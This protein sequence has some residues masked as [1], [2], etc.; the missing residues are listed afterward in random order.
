MDAIILAGG[1]SAEDP[2]AA[3]AKG[4]PKSMIGIAGKPMVQWVLDAVSEAPSVTNVAL[5]G[6]E[7]ASMLK[8][9]KPMVTLPDLGSLI[10]NIQQGAQHFQQVHPQETHILSLS[11]DIPTVTAKIIETMIEKYTGLEYDIYYSVVERKVMEERFPG[12]RR[13]YLKVKDGEF[14]GGDLNCYSKKAALDPN[15]LWKELIKLRKSPLKQAAMIGYG[16]LIL[17]LLRQ[18]TL[19][20][21]AARVCQRLGITGNALCVPFAEIGMDVD[22]PFQFDMVQADLLR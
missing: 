20:S 3:M 2:L 8:C 18:I 11:A 16:T 13:T 9:Q 21:A 12:S 19:N 22:K 17:L 15:A 10:A 5:I 14:C 7:D 1:A 4:L 6:L